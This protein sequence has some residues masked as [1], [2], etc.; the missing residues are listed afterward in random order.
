MIERAVWGRTAIG[1]QGS[2]WGAIRHAVSWLGSVVA[3]LSHA[4]DADSAPRRKD[5][6]A[7]A[8]P[9]AATRGSDPHAG[10]AALYELHARAVLGY[11]CAR[12]PT[13]DDAEDAL[14]EVFLAALAQCATGQAPGLGWLLT[15][16]RRR[17]ADFYRRRHAAQALTAAM[18]ARMATGGDGLEDAALR[19]EMVREALL[20]VAALPDDQRD[21]LALRFAAGLRAPQIATVLGKSDEATRALLSRALRRLRKELAG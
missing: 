4:Q 10:V 7:P 18:A 5:V 12:L 21:A 16:A 17:A 14:A 6:D 15:V 2:W 20:R 11:L 9:A 8:S 1:W 13:L 3:A 19:A